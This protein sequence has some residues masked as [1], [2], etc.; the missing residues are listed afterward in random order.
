MKNSN[1]HNWQ[2]DRLIRMLSP[3]VVLYNYKAVLNNY[4]ATL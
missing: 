1:Y 2:F 4:N 3:N